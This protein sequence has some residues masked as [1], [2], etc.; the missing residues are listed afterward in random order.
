M[1]SDCNVIDG[2]MAGKTI[3]LTPFPVGFSH[4]VPTPETSHLPH[5]RRI[6]YKYHVKEQKMEDGSTR[7]VLS[8]RP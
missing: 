8:I 3:D 4:S 2:P 1:S 7:K 5:H 6:H